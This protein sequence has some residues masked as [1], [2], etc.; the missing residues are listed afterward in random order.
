MED[1]EKQLPN[2]EAQRAQRK[3]HV[4]GVLCGLCVSALSLPVESD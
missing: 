2:A 1:L 3:N 4:L